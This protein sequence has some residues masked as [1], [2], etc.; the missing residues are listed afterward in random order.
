M[1]LGCSSI[2]W[3]QPPARDTSAAAVGSASIRGRVT[4]AAGHPLPRVEV[5]A[6]PAPAD[7][8][9][10][11]V[12]TDVDG[13]YE[14]VNLPAGTYTIV[15]AKANYVRTSWGEPRPEGPGKR[16]PLADGQTLANV[17]LRMQRTGAI[18]GK[19]VDE[20]G[21]PVT[22]VLVQAMRYQYVQG[23]RRL[24]PSGRGGSTNDIGEFRI[25]G[26]TPGQYYV[27]ATLRNFS[28]VNTDTTDHSGYAPTFFPGTG[29]QAEAQRMAIAPGQTITGINLTLLPIQTATVSGIVIDLDGQRL[30]NGMVR[31]GSK[32]PTGGFGFVG[33]TL[34]EGRFAVN[35]LTPGDYT[36]TV[37]KAGGSESATAD[38]TVSGSDIS[39][40]Q[41][42]LAPPS[43]IRGRIVFTPSANGS[44]PPKPTA[45]DL[46]AVREWALGQQGRFPAKIKDDGTFEISL[47]ANHV[48]LR[49]APVG[50]G[51]GNNGPPPWR[52]GRVIFAGTDVGDSGIDVGANATIENVVVEMTNRVSEVNGTVTDTEGKIVRDAV[53]IVFA[54]DPTRWTVQTRWLST[55]R[56]GP[57][58]TF[59]ARLLPGDY[60][61]VAMTD[62]EN[63][64]WTDAD[65]LALAREHATKFSVA[66]GE[67]KT[68]DLAVSPTPVY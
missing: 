34:R 47:P 43:T 46:G 8:E 32:T 63:G 1:A 58:D 51:A 14:I 57:D 42:Q 23:S 40:L 66:D 59:R 2:G 16:I 67:K 44:D 17:D 3:A 24:M 28:V 39:G 62:V 11:A 49:A 12:L 45:Y 5:R 55:T 35:G 48:Q 25:F 7:I 37:A 29:N 15:A 50:G 61:A 20:F 9:G 27:S 6:G 13:R 56:P 10:R 33:S 22:G 26:L 36:I 38:V 18:T 52:I 60:Y 41:I 31:I 30:L 4:D 21:D 53:V 54:Q 19:I 64:A 65:F 68:L